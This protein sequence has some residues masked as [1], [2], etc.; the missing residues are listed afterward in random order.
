[1]KKTTAGDVIIY[2]LFV[3]IG[4]IMLYPF[5][6]TLVGSL[7]TYN[8]FINT[9]FVIFPKKI[10]LESYIHIFKMGSIIEPMKTTIIITIFG[11]ILSLAMTAYTAYG[12]SMQ[13][14][15]RNWIMAFIVFTMIV[16]GGLIPEFVLYKNLGLVNT[17]LVYIIPFLINTFNLIIMRTSF[18]EFPVEIKESARIDG[19]NE[20]GVF[21][22]FVLPL[23]KPVLVTILLF[24]AVQYWNT[25]FPSLFFVTD[26]EKK[27]LQDNLYRILANISDAEAAHSTTSVVFSENIKMANVIITTLPILVVY[28]FLQR[29][30]IKGAM[31]GAI[32]G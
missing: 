20:F 6:Y 19:C 5:W 23:S 13:F 24:Y 2:T 10:T 22:R 15:G 27:T 12:L 7:M 11:T 16:K 17:R 4:L 29:Y 28:P 26:P 8:E 1:M 25:F 32:K 3:I 9:V 31:V 18:M 21:F 14:K 30:F